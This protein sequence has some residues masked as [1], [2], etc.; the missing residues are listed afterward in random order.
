MEESSAV[1]H[2]PTGE[3]LGC[4]QIMVVS[5]RTAARY[6]QLPKEIE[7]PRLQRCCDEVPPGGRPR[8]RCAKTL[9]DLPLA[10][11]LVTQETLKLLEM[12]RQKTFPLLLRWIEQPCLFA[13]D[14]PDDM[15]EHHQGTCLVDSQRYTF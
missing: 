9:A 13:F 14:T 6:A 12:I 5:L 4:F 10:H 11:A 1:S 3:L 15:A 8:V 7:V 2:Q